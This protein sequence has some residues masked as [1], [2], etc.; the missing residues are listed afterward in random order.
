MSDIKIVRNKNAREFLT[1]NSEILRKNATLNNLIL[2]IPLEAI[3][4][5]IDD[6]KAIYLTV[7]QRDKI[8]GQAVNRDESRNLLISQMPKEIIDE[9]ISFF[10][11]I[12]KNSE[13]FM[14]KKTSVK[15]P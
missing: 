11:N 13:V 1:L 10:Y 3:K 6:Q 5:L 7:Y 2:G 4:G 14:G 15:K 9:V 12:R 8:I